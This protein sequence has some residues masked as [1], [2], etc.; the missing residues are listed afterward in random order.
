MGH[1]VLTHM[2]VTA[3]EVAVTI[4]HKIIR[5]HGLPDTI[6]SDRD[7]KFTATLLQELHRVL[8]VKL[9]LSTAFHPQTDGS[10]ERANRTIAQ[11]MRSLVD[12]AQNNWADILPA[13]ELAINSSISS[14]TGFAPFELNYGWIPRLIHYPTIDTSLR[15]V[16]LLAQQAAE[17]I[18]HAFDGI[19]ASH[20]YMCGQANKKRRQDDLALAIGSKAN[21]ST[22][23]RSLP[24]G[25]TGKLTPK[26]IRPYPKVGVNKPAP[27]ILWSYQM[28]Q[29]NGES[30]PFS[31]GVYYDPVFQI[32]TN[33]FRRDMQVIT[34]TSGMTPILNGWLTRLSTMSLRQKYLDF[35]Y[36]GRK[37][38]IHGNRSISVTS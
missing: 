5:L 15:G 10:T 16:Q 36:D 1:L 24:K 17:N 9:L 23:N 35:I 26:C 19:I 18:D 8:G 20:I 7:S 12:S 29:N 34:M 2:K 38:T 25:R 11:I 30:T 28:N 31:M 6:V 3:A 33:C 14:S 13:T 21:L 4:A 32:T 27:H 22:K 37:E